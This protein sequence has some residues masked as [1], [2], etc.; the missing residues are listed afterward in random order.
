MKIAF[1]HNGNDT[2]IK[3]I[4][5]RLS[6][7]HETQSMSVTDIQAMFEL[8]MWSDV[9]WF[10]WC[11]EHIVQ[12][13]HL[14]R[15]CK[16]VVRLHRYEAFLKH[17]DEVNWDYVDRLV[18]VTDIIKP[19]LEGRTGKVKRQT[20]KNGVDL[21]KIHFK[22]KSK[23]FK[24]GF[25]AY[26]HPRKNFPMVLQII[27]KLVDID[28]RYTLYIAG[29][30]TDK[31][32]EDYTNYLVKEMGIENNVIFCGWVNNIGDWLKD[33]NYVVSGSTYE[34]FGY[35]IAEGMASG[36]KPIIHNFPGVEDIWG[37]DGLFNT[38]DEAVEMIQSDKFDSESYRE[39]I[40]ENYNFEDKI[41]EIEKMLKGL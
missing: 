11:I 3:P 16:M 33:I 21:S 36:A 15:V 38:V 5:E 4:I 41:V 7:T 12:A 40:Q 23:G 19:Y 20:I 37:K 27:K 29:R 13:S 10:E 8:M 31:L 2:F 17:P 32:T 6:K 22:K 35:N 26:I 28:P 34:S 9:S 25:I 18:L 24:L 39:Y 14:P 1:F 30:Y